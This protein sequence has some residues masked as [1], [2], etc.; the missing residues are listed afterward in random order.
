MTPW[1]QQHRAIY[2]MTVADAVVLGK[3]GNPVIRDHVAPLLRTLTERWEGGDHTHALDLQAVNDILFYA[4][5]DEIQAAIVE[6]L[7]P[8]PKSWREIAQNHP[9]YNRSPQ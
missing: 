8:A 2:Q 9:L 4:T 3:H 1:K 7:N 5:A 6:V